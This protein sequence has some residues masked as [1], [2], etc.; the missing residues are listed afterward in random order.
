ME[1]REKTAW[2]LFTTALCISIFTT[3]MWIKYPHEIN[4]IIE[5]QKVV[6]VEVPIDKIIDRPVI[7][8]IYKKTPLTIDQEFLIDTGIQLRDA[9]NLDKLG[10]LKSI[11]ELT[12][13]VVSSDE[14]IETSRIKDM[15]EIRLRH[16]GIKI[17]DNKKKVLSVI[18]LNNGKSLEIDSQIREN[19]IVLRMNKFYSITSATWFDIGFTTIES[20]DKK[21]SEM[22]DTFLNIFEKSN[23]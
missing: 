5:V 8:T 12:I 3:I 20:I 22:I 21:M 7:K 11:D 2:L 19:A 16:S 6:N 1:D 9:G 18:I 4:H 14:S 13:E 10:K 23:Q 17:T 15:I